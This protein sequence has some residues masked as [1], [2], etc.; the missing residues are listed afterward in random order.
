MTPA[1]ARAQQRAQ[2]HH[3]RGPD[4]A[5]PAACCSG[6]RAPRA[7]CPCR[8]PAAARQRRP[9]AQKGCCGT[10]HAAVQ[11]SARMAQQIK[12][13]PAAGST[14]LAGAGGRS[15]THAALPPPASSWAW[16]CGRTAAAAAAEGSVRSPPT[17]GR[18]AAAGQQE[19]LPRQHYTGSNAS[20]DRLRTGYRQAADR[21]QT[22]CGRA[23]DRLPIPHRTHGFRSL[24]FII[25]LTSANFRVFLALPMAAPHRGRAV[26]RRRW[27]RHWRRG[28][29]LRW[30]LCNACTLGNALEHW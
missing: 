10:L 11:G 22:G 27:R 8:R 9:R 21:L 29:Q 7:S 23:A 4:R 18:P 5:A 26:S 6:R 12:Q 1:A 3:R 15:L 13:Q 2:Q 25:R 28:R 16:A 20:V 14:R 17:A 30:R 24:G 19:A